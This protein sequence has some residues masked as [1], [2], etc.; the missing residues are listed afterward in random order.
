MS[1]VLTDSFRAEF[2]Q[3]LLGTYFKG[4][5][6]VSDEDI[7]HHVEL[8]YLAF[9]DYLVPWVN[10]FFPLD[11]ASL[12]EVGSGTGSSTLAFAETGAKIHT[13]EISESSIEAARLRFSM[14]GFDGQVSEHAELF[15]RNCAQFKSGE[16][17]D[18]VL[19]IATLEHMTF[20]E[21]QEILKTSWEILRPGGILVVAD[22]PNRL[23]PMDFHTSHLPFF[24]MLPPKVR[25][26]YAANSPREGFATEF[27]KYPPEQREEILV[28]W[29]NGV[30]YHDFELAIGPEIHS[31][32]IASGY[33]PIISNAWSI[34]FEDSILMATFKHYALPQ[35]IAFTRHNLFMIIQK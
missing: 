6:Q 31:K 20:E 33:E 23:C 21:A 14:A 3:V 19:L 5:P 10:Q 4:W 35:H 11:G 29:G 24:S 26:S 28:R 8:R 15:D 13:Y 1:F 22:T 25:I 18:G 30:S 34:L 9:R 17:V 2:R 12:V 27:Q 16:K 32:I 7:R